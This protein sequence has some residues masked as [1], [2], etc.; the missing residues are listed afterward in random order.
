MGN[1]TKGSNPLLSAF[2]LSGCSVARLSRLL[3]E[4]EAAGSN[5]ATPTSKSHFAMQNGILQ[6]KK[7]RIHPGLFLIVKAQKPARLW[8]LISNNPLQDHEVILFLKAQKL[9]KLWD[10]VSNNPTT[11]SRSNPVSKAQSLPQNFSIKVLK[12]KWVHSSAG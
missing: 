2:F 12:Q 1:C 9:E 11:G 7:D 6:S 10:L 4:Q 5:P 3:W 8:D